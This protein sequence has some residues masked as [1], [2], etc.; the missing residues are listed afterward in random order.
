MSHTCPS[1]SAT[2]T[3]SALLALGAALAVTFL[4]SCGAPT[5]SGDEPPDGGIGPRL[6]AA[7]GGAVARAVAVGAD[8]SVA[9][10]FEAYGAGSAGGWNGAL[11]VLEPDGTT[12]FDLTVAAGV[13]LVPNA[14]AEARVGVG[15]AHAG[16][17]VAGPVQIGEGVLVRLDETG[18]EVCRATTVG[19]PNAIARL[20]TGA[21]VVVGE[22]PTN[23]L[24][25]ADGFAQRF[26]GDCDEVWLRTFGGP[27]R[28]FALDAAPL[29]AGF[30][31]VGGVDPGS[32][33][34]VDGAPG[35]RAFVSTW[36]A[37][38]N[39]TWGRV[40][41][42]F[43]WFGVAA[44]VA[45][46]PTS[47]DLFVTGFADGEFE[48]GANLGGQ[49]AFVARVRPGA[50]EPLVWGR[51][52]GSATSDTGWSVAAT[53]D[54][55][56]VVAGYTDGALTGF[57]SAGSSDVWVARLSGDGVV[58]WAWQAGTEGYDAAYGV[59][60]TAAGRSVTVGVA[61]DGFLGLAGL[62]ADDAD[63]SGDHGFIVM[64]RA[65]GTVAP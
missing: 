43:E 33:W 63:A 8:G 40:L 17:W 28:D 11:L 60:T 13:S 1:P 22:M 50:A 54:G 27:G 45:A 16:W 41:D 47:G 65:D 35:V 55:D 9:V 42:V 38:G 15:D 53:Q 30:A 25:S 61:K 2:S 14:L 12:R 58:R 18:S 26:A 24:L 21:V 7:P 48:S 64:H 51:N 52:L 6:F 10:S 32:P 29:G 31:L 36:D 44:G 5:P 59:A 39:L 3:A 34:H 57:T 4:A 19:S 49:D 37:D 56:V 62:V 23:G 46:D 20:S